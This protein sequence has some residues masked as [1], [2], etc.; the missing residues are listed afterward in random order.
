MEG[1]LNA[2]FLDGVNTETLGVSK[3]I[4]DKDGIEIRKMF[5]ELV[6]ISSNIFIVGSV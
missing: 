5:I 4:L 1:N 3:D 6:H 2:S